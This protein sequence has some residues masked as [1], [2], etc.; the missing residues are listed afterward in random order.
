[1]HPTSH[2]NFFLPYCPSSTLRTFQKHAQSSPPRFTASRARQ[3]F[4]GTPTNYPS[5]HSLL[6]PT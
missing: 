2:F 1:M 5:A 3:P 4:L 6:L